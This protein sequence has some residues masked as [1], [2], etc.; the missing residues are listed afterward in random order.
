M[1]MSAFYIVLEH[2]L[3]IYYMKFDNKIKKERKYALSFLLYI[4]GI[5][6]NYTNIFCNKPCLRCF[7]NSTLE[8]CFSII[9]SIFFKNKLICF[10]SCLTGSFI[11][12]SSISFLVNCGCAEPKLSKSICFFPNG[13]AKYFVIKNDLI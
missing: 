9:L 10:Y 3:I 5:Y 6:Q 13:E 11:L 8:D 2:M 7:N 4:I 12:Y 1:Q